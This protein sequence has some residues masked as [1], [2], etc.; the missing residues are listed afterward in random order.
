MRE[1]GLLGM[2][3][4]PRARGFILIG[5]CFLSH[6]RV[7]ISSSFPSVGCIVSVSCLEKRDLVREV[8]TEGCPSHH[9][10]DSTAMSAVTAVIGPLLQESGLLGGHTCVRMSS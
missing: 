2:G 5:M 7:N 6:P 3:E 4:S 8:R 1:Q 9:T 10:E